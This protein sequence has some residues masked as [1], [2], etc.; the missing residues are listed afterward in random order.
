MSAQ[1]RLLSEIYSQSSIPL[2]DLLEEMLRLSPSRRV[3]AD[4][5]LQYSWFDGTLLPSSAS[6]WYGLDTR[7]DLSG[8]CVEAQDGCKLVDLLEHELQEA[9]ERWG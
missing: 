2:L 7:V 8:R 1:P 6:A 9:R 5:A 3:K 4:T